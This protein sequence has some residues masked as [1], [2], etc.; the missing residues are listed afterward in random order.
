MQNFFYSSSNHFSWDI[1]IFQNTIKEYLISLALIV[2][3]FFAF[4]I[5]KN[6]LIKK[7]YNLSKKTKIEIDDLIIKVIKNIDIKFYLFLAFYLGTKNLI[8]GNLLNKILYLILTAWITYL[9]IIL[10]QEIINHFFQ[11][12]IKK[13]SGN[14]SQALK[15]INVIVRSIL[16]VI[17]SLFMLSNMG[18]NVSSAMAGLGI[19]GITIALALQ[20]ILSDLF[21]SFAIYF[22]KP[23]EVGDF[24][25][26]GNQSGTVS[27]IGIKSTRLEALQG[28]EII[29][30][31]QELT[32]NRIQNFK[33]LK[34]RR[35]VS[36]VGVTYS[37]NNQKLEK[38]KEI[39]K[40]IIDKIEKVEFSRCHFSKFQDSSLEFEIVYYIDSN[41]YGLYMDAQE[42]IN[43]EIKKVFEKEKIEMAFPTQ[44]IYLN[45]E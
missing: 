11:K 35:I 13:E 45:R 26:T 29:I 8:L 20:N 30:S 1:A 39:V 14:T 23:F 28:E 37:T 9:I 25:S 32:K 44:T 6:Y 2:L 19:G 34:R 21:S 27:K 5:L 22:D 41:D 38:I 15:T 43:L 4:K 3:F 10:A 24:I 42:K 16:W 31:N 18:I 33:K 7:I 12:K 36:H 40:N 17:G